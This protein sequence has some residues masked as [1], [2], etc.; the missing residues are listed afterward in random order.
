MC[1]SEKWRFLDNGYGVETG[2]NSSDFE[3]FMGDPCKSL[4]REICQNSIDAGV[5]DKP[6]FVEFKRFNIKSSSVPGINDLREQITDCW[7]YVQKDSK[8][9]KKEKNILNRMKSCIDAENIQCLRIS[10]FNTTGLD[11]V[12]TND[13]EGAFYNLTKGSGVSKKCGST[14]GSKGI[15]KFVSFIVSDIN[16]VFYST[17]AKDGGRGFIGVNRLPSIPVPSDPEL[18]TSGIGY[19]GLS[20]KH[21][22]ILRELNLDN[23]FIRKDSEYG[24]DVYILGID[25]DIYS[26]KVLIVTILNSFI[27]AIFRDKL[28]VKIGETLIN[29]ENLNKLVYEDYSDSKKDIKDYDNIILNIKATYEMLSNVDGV[30]HGTLDI[31][32][33]VV[34]IYIRKYST[35]E[36]RQQLATKKCSMV[37]YPY[38]K[39]LDKSKCSALPFSALCI[40]GDN[41]LNQ[42]LRGIENPEHTNWTLKRVNY[43]KALYRATRAYYKEFQD[44]VVEFIQNSLRT[45]S[46]DA[47]DVE[48][49]GEYL[50]N[51]EEIGENNAEPS[52]VDAAIVSPVKKAKVKKSRALINEVNDGNTYGAGFDGVEND[53]EDIYDDTYDVDNDGDGPWNRKMGASRSSAQNTDP[54]SGPGENESH[55]SKHGNNTYKKDRLEGIEYRNILVNKE[56]GVYD[57]VFTSPVNDEHCD[58]SVYIKGDSKDRI[59]VRIFSATING[60]N[61]KVIDGKIVD[62]SLKKETLY[63]I[64]Y[65][66]NVK[67]IFACEVIIDAYR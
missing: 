19:Y 54:H 39:I 6:V 47:I 15:G 16:T 42:K 13:R 37:R 56:D 24:A 57:C 26:E 23:T 27:V 30:E 52:I 2:V 11:G 9:D 14:G 41:E 65:K 48:G 62:F 29:K 31:K 38:M 10:D 5:G 8:R 50:P 20:E 12:E 64:R 60:Q 4:A 49:A 18:S 22:P 44:K 34:D 21:R 66:V 7:E 43:D 33:S 58:F 55:T 17:Y 28:I 46:E 61:C 40:I 35:A 32:G 3:T 25:N 45:F 1:A 53:D 51:Q 63:K 59:Q 67:G 36:Q